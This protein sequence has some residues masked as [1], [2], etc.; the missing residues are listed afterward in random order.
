MTNAEVYAQRLAEARARIEND[1][2]AGLA[3]TRLDLYRADLNEG[4]L[5]E[6]SRRAELAQ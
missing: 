6:E 1:R 2:R 3:P 4:L 5:L